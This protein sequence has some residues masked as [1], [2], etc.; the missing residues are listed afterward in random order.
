MVLWCVFIVNIDNSAK[1]VFPIHQ[2]MAYSHLC[3]QTCNLYYSTDC[4]QDVAT[5]PTASTDPNG[6]GDAFLPESACSSASASA[7]SGGSDGCVSSLFEVLSD[8]SRVEVRKN[9]RGSVVAQV[10]K[11]G[12]FGTEK[13][14]GEIKS[15]VDARTGAETL[16]GKCKC[17]TSKCLCW[18]SSANHVDLLIAWI[19]KGSQCDM[20][21][22]LELA[23]DLK[24]GIG[25][26]V[27]G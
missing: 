11:I 13:I 14:L 4:C 12:V 20:Q 21:K 19:A 25:M 17:H 7:R 18:L 3:S 23:R 22:H 26:R 5:Q 6:V 8:G 27:R 2:P 24:I 9:Q 16:Q 15:L 10:V 1:L